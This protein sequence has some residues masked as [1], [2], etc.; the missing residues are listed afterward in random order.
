M[1]ICEWK[2]NCETSVNVCARMNFLKS[3]PI[4]FLNPV[5]AKFIE[6]WIVAQIPDTT[7]NLDCSG[8]LLL[9][10][11]MDHSAES[12][13]RELC[14]IH[15]FTDSYCFFYCCR[16][17]RWPKY[18]YRYRACSL[19]SSLHPPLKGPKPDWF[20]W[21]KI[22]CLCG[23]GVGFVPVLRWCYFTM[24]LMRT[25]I[26]DVINSQPLYPLIQSGYFTLG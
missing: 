20:R 25:N 24:L 1:R 8:S 4:H 5:F 26:Q 22:C 7:Q 6:N 15:L 19:R 13:V 14:A 11:N 16:L 2:W 9:A 18:A 23:G 3:T 12:K 21:S 10:Q 17:L